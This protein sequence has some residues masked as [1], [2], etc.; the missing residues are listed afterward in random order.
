MACSRGWQVGAGCWEVMVL[1]V[2][3][4]WQLAFTGQMIQE[5]EQGGNYNHFFFFFSLALGVIQH[6]FCDLCNWVHRFALIFRVGEVYTK[7]WIYGKGEH[8]DHFGGTHLAHICSVFTLRCSFGIMVCVCVCVFIGNEYWIF[9]KFSA[10]MQIIMW[11]F[12]L[13]LWY[14]LVIDFLYW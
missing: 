11:F 12:S 6:H 14:F 1:S 8:W 13:D 7:K 3:K 9:K 2:L 10:F 5:R 4:T